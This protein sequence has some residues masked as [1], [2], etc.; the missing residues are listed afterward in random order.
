MT[1]YRIPWVPIL[2]EAD[3]PDTEETWLV[4]DNTGGVYS[5]WRCPETGVWENAEA[6]YGLRVIA[7]APLPAPY[8][9]DETK[10]LGYHD[11]AEYYKEPEPVDER[12]VRIVELEA[13]VV[14]L[15]KAMRVWLAGADTI[16]QL[17]KEVE[18]ALLAVLQPG[19]LEM[20]E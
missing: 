5:D 8:D 17:A 20:S 10:P 18:T 12:D 19:D 13:R 4:T 9:P 14:R 1:G 16:E 2:S 15:A 3:L 7:Y 6:E 11:V